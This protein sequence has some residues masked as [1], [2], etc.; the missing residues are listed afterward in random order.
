MTLLICQFEC[1]HNFI[2]ILHFGGKVPGT[3]TAGFPSLAKLQAVRP[4]SIDIEV[5]ARSQSNQYGIYGGK[6]GAVEGFLHVLRFS[7][8]RIIPAM[9]RNHVSFMHHPTIVGV[10]TMVRVEGFWVRSLR[11]QENFSSLEV[12]KGCV[13]HSTTELVSMERGF[14]C[15]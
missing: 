13:V 15:R 11:G 6:C 14:P 2:L 7:H 5:L 8:A 9:L 10:K 3:F 1:R 4:W 12:L